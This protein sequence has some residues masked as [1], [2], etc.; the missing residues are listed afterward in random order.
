MLESNGSA[1]L[2][3]TI[4]NDGLLD[5]SYYIDVTMSAP[6]GWTGE[7]TTPNGTFPFGQQDLVAVQSGNSL[8]VD[9]SVLPN[10]ING[11]GE[12]TLQFTSMNDPNIS[13]TA[14]F[15]VVTVSGLT[16][17]II[18]ASG[19]GYGDVLI[20]GFE[21]EFGYPYGIVSSEALYPGVDL[22]NF[23]LIAWST[24]NALP[25]FTEDEV[26]ALIPFLDNGGR[27]LINGQNL[28]E[29]IFDPSGQSQFAQSF[30][31][32]YLHAS[33]VSDAGL[34][35]F[36][37][38]ISGDPI[39][40]SLNFSLTTLYPRSPDQ[41]IPNDTTAS[42]LFTFSTYPQYNSIKADDG[43]DRVVYF[44]FGLEQ[45]N[46][47]TVKDS[48]LNRAIRWLMNGVVVGVENKQPVV[49]T[50][51]LD[52]NYPNPF[53]PSTT[54]T[55]NLAGDVNVNLKIYDLMGQEVA[56]LVNEKQTSGIHQVQFDAGN[57]ASGMY[58]YRLTAGDFI[59]VKK[60]TL[61]K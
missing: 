55:Y 6:N 24:G 37:K 9:M 26:N 18:D 27:L 21:Q 53:N 25:V 11:F 56:Q 38:G 31:N 33:Y 42:S 44:G 1:D 2:S 52:Q 8:Q 15:R 3:A 5:D 30:Y 57:L 41:F 40:D 58:F 49:N 35:F 61:I 13:A 46:D 7:Y 50:F 43:V 36:F 39:S 23:N 59:S 48:L 20:N 17:L 14:R 45:I 34:T 22:T 4:R 16:G 28:G 32:N 47:Q 51:K 60:M 19:E 54:I 29:D 12:I 10:V